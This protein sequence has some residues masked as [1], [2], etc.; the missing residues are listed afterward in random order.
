MEDQSE[1]ELDGKKEKRFGLP[2]RIDPGWATVLASTLALIGTLA[3]LI[4]RNQPVQPSAP[5]DTPA[6]VV[7][8]PGS[9][10]PEP[11][12]TATDPPPTPTSPPPTLAPESTPDPTA[13]TAPTPAAGAEALPTVVT[14]EGLS[15]SEAELAQESAA[16]ILRL[17]RTMPL[18][19]RDPFDVNDYDWPEFTDTFAEGLECEAAISDQVYRITVQ[20]AETVGPAA[21]MTV[22]PRLASNFY[23]TFDID[24]SQEHNGDILVY[25]RFVDE[26]NFYYLIIHPQTQM[27]TLG[28]RQD[29]VDS[30]AIEKFLPEIHKTDSN[31]ITMIM[32]GDLGTLFFNDNLF[33]TFYHESQ[34]DKGLIQL[35]LRLNEAGAVEEL[36]IDN[37]ELRGD[38]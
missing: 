10:T 35:G 13:T 33:S 8:L 2:H 27:L 22:A 15:P 11:I 37:F 31:K 3:A 25:F 17:G 24:L 34:M 9:A 36:V 7:A 21:C 28:V 30:T 6:Q 19:I 23:L 38:L 29:G 26:K 5:T 16:S 32:V 4:I 20:S 14:L 12:P 18:I 1:K